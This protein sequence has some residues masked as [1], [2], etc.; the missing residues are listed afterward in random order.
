MADKYPE[1]S[2]SLPDRTFDN[3]RDLL[4]ILVVTVGPQMPYRITF[5]TEERHCSTLADNADVIVGSH[6]QC[7]C[8]ED[9]QKGDIEGSQRS[10]QKCSAN[11]I[12][13]V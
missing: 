5:S 4:R 2:S 11:G 10:F 6:V 7:T 8:L 12:E 9:R 3:Y 13:E 1:K